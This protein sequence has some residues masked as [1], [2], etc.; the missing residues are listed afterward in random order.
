MHMLRWLLMVVVLGGS[1]PR[2]ALAEGLPDPVARVAAALGVPSD[3][4]SL[5]VQPLDAVAPLASH[6]PDTP[7]NPASVMKLV[8][9]FAALQ[10]LN[11]AYTWRT[12][13]HALGPIED[14]VLRGD[15][16]IRGGGDPYL[17]AEEFWK[18][19]G[20]LRERGLRRIEGDLVFDVSRFQLPPE[21]PGRFDGRPDRVYNLVP[22]PLL[23][24]FNA[25]RFEFQPGGDGRSVHVTTV[26]ELHNLQV[27]NRLSLASGGCSGYQRG[28]TLSVQE[29]ARQRV[30]LEG[31]FPN[32]CRDYRLTRTVLQPESYAYALFKLYF[33][34]LGG[35]FDG[36]WRWGQL[37]VVEGLAAALADRDTASGALY[38]HHSRPLGEL[39]RLVNKY[40]N[41][42]MTR[43]LEL[44]LGAERFGWPATPQN[45]NR[46][47]IEILEAHGLDTRGMVIDNAAGLSR[48]GRLTAR[49]M[50]RLLQVAWEAPYMPEF[51]SSMAL[52][53]LDGTLTRRFNGQPSL[54]RMHLK[55]GSLNDVSG[56]AGYVHTASNRRLLVV[57]LVNSPESHRGP[58]EELQDALLDW[59]F[60]Q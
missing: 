15:L 16:L 7:R 12:E 44:A 32:G 37:P 48:D 4:L 43:H 45:G 34:Q 55:T 59:A 14:G 57:L 35:Q 36:G 5:W 41:N 6:L 49:Q 33:R 13:V 54:G 56:I 20:G 11:P 38:V 50:A 40:S 3:H 24:N 47:M 28:I 30:L 25:M 29:S 39:V 21:D 52:S 19:V 31:R 27:L 58:G 9:S 10:G 60:R 23:V 53:G 46:A 18:L 2:P 51:V 42:V 26:P 22:H 8:T 17:V 1:A